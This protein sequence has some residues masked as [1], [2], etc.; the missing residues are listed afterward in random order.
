MITANKKSYAQ[1]YID[2]WNDFT[3]TYEEFYKKYVNVSHNAFYGLKSPVRCA[4]IALVIA[5]ITVLIMA[6]GNKSRMTASR[7]DYMNKRDLKVHVA[8]DLF[9]RTTTKRYKISSES[10]GGHGGSFHSSGGHSH[11]GGGRHM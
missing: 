10:S 8:Q 3:G 7:F 2:N 1:K 6:C 4:L 11:G 9:I 5:G